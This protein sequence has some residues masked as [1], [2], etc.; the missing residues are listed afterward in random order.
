MS[1]SGGLEAPA[2]ALG[3]F[4]GGPDG[5]PTWDAER[6]PVATLLATA[7]ISNLRLSSSSW[8]SRPAVELEPVLSSCYAT[9]SLAR[10]FLFFPARVFR[11]LN[12]L[13]ISALSV[14]CIGGLLCAKVESC[15]VR[16]LLPLNSPTKS[17]LDNILIVCVIH[18]RCSRIE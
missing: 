5:R 18:V 17:V 11:G 12:K 14:P 4:I 1:L 9:S 16:L 8:S 10:R 13:L 15:L 6:K 7:R 3:L 2:V